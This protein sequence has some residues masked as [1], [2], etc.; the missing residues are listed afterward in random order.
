MPPAYLTNCPRTATRI[1]ALRERG[2]SAISASEAVTGFRVSHV[3][4]ESSR[5]ASFTRRS[6][7]E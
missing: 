2:F 5:K 7:R 4:R 1:F 3:S 6:S